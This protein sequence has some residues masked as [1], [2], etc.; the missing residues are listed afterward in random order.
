VDAVTDVY[1]QGTFAAAG[2]TDLSALPAGAL[3]SPTSLSQRHADV[4][5]VGGARS[6]LKAAAMVARK[7]VRR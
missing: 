2:V 3:R 6:L 4:V 7:S 5:V 1:G